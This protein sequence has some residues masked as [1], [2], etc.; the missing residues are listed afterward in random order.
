[1]ETFCEFPKDQARTNGIGLAHLR[2]PVLFCWWYRRRDRSGRSSVVFADTRTRRVAWHSTLAGISF[3]ATLSAHGVGVHPECR[4]I[5]SSAFP[6][7][8]PVVL[9]DPSSLRL[10]RSLN[11]GGQFVAAWSRYRDRIRQPS[12]PALV[13]DR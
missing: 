5:E 12:H 8:L 7:K 6:V 3:L 13:H 2:Q 9:S 1:M 11:G 10:A 4:V